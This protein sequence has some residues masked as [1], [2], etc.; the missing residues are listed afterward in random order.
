MN[1]D[2]RYYEDVGELSEA[3]TAENANVLLKAGWELLA[4]RERATVRLDGKEVR[5]VIYVLGKKAPAHGAEAPP[6]AEKKAPQEKFF[7]C[8]YC[9]AQIKWNRDAEGKWLP[10][11]PDG[12]VHVCQK[13]EV[14]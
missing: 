14:K 6:P 8:K 10:T 2:D 1:E 7:S 12:S 9:G 5:E 13:K 11:N 3:S 4:I